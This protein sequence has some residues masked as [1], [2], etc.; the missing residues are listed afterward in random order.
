MI[1]YS[2]FPILLV[3]FWEGVN[4][5]CSLLHPFRESWL[6]QHHLAAEGLGTD[7]AARHPARP[8][9]RLEGAH[10]PGRRAPR[11]LLPGELGSQAVGAADLKPSLLPPHLVGSEIIRSFQS[12]ST[13]TCGFFE[14]LLLKN[15]Y[16]IACHK[17]STT[18]DDLIQS[19]RIQSPVVFG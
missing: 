12:L 6:R 17:F 16:P 1:I 3:T 15:T 14:K 19:K 2:H 9:L 10:G 7:E 13:S 4:I 5:K 11:A 18:F 8:H